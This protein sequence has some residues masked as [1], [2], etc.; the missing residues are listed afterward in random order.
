MGNDV[1]DED[2]VDI[3]KASRL[4]KETAQQ[5]ATRLNRSVGTVRKIARTYGRGFPRTGK[6]VGGPKGPYSDDRKEAIR[7]GQRAAKARR[8]GVEV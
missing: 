6:P 3:C 5:V 2:K 8:E 1:S 4:G 7:A